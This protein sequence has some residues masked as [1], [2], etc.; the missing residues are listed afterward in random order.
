MPKP[1]IR[2]GVIAVTVALALLVPAA[3]AARIRAPASADANP[4]IA[5]ALRSVV[6][7]GPSRWGP[8]SGAG[9]GFVFTSG[10]EV[11]TNAHVVGSARWVSVTLFDGR[12]LEAVVV[13]VD[14]RTDI[15]VI[16][17]PPDARVTPLQIAGPDRVTPPGAPVYA[18]GHPMGFQFSVTSGVIAGEGRFYD[19]VT[20][21]AFLQHD[22]ALNPG[23][24]GGPLVDETGVVLGMNSATP[25]Q[26]LFD[27][28]IGLAIPAFE[29]SEI[30]ERLIA[31]GVIQRGALGLR[32]SHADA[33][34]AAA[35]G[36]G[37]R[38]GALIDTVE[39]GGA[40]ERAGL[41]PG[42][43]ILAIEGEPV[44]LPREV[45]ART[46]AHGPGDRVRVDF[47]RSG[48]RRSAIVTLQRDVPED[49]ARLH[50]GPAE[51]E[52]LG[53]SF[54][55]SAEGGV[56]VTD[57]VSGS[58]AQTYGIGSGD[59]IQA[60]N[61]VAVDGPD[62]A[63]ERLAEATG[64]LVVLRVERLGVGVRHINLPRTRA[65][66]ASRPPGLPTEQPSPPL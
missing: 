8:A 46:M 15:A 30:A 38:A 17:L 36:A 39:R 50:T 24:S 47:V 51:P 33:M 44:A 25:P 9:S 4:G 53:L 56:R 20:P 5:R 18:L 42:D 34:V 12:V 32:V 23:S 66:A 35:L 37:A 31:D 28:G 59:R 41:E 52:T 45:V 11:M 65:G 13:G 61:G 1:I 16:R 19:V 49:P 3:T 14:V 40:S 29:A 7:I 62:A 64:R 2:P 43:L 58:L 26:T 63:L 48:R 54:G 10:G 55:P 60:V 22:A 6:V 27:I 57:V 21:V